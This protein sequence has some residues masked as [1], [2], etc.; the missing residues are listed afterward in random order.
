MKYIRLFIWITGI[1]LAIAA[2]VQLYRMHKAFGFWTVIE[3]IYL[4]LPPVL[5]IGI[6]Y[7]LTKKSKNNTFH[8]VSLV[9]L[10]GVLGCYTFLSLGLEMFINA[11]PVTDVSQY[12]NIMD[13][14]KISAL[15]IV[16]HFPDPIPPDAQEVEFYFSPGFLQADAQLQLKYKTTPK[17]IVEYYEEYSRITTKSYCGDVPYYFLSQKSENKIFE[18]HNDFETLEFDKDPNNIPEHGK[19]HG[20]IINR[21]ENVIIFWAD[22]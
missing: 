16:S 4:G 5:F 22:W 6:A 11:R 14:W 13:Q 15:D 3:F 19:R 2:P 7:I 21:K 1:L 9:C 20:V 12:K 17:K 10:M 8:V 18:S